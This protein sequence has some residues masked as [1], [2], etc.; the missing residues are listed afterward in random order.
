M[1]P[2]LVL[3]TKSTSRTHRIHGTG[4][5]TYIWLF[6]CGIYDDHGS[7][8]VGPKT[9]YKR[10]LPICNANMY[11]SYFTPCILPGSRG[12][13]PWPTGRTSDVD[14]M[15]PRQPLRLGM[16][17]VHPRCWGAQLP[18]FGGLDVWWVCGCIQ[19]PLPVSRQKSWINWWKFITGLEKLGE[20]VRPSETWKYVAIY[21]GY[22]LQL[23]LKNGPSSKRPTLYDA[24]GTCFLLASVWLQIDL[25]FKGKWHD[26]QVDNG[27][28]L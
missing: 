9:S 18:I 23:H 24:T 4:I 20:I 12:G 17:H 16:K 27:W 15:W 2:S 7:Y 8:R 19:G 11:R 3:Y 22:T 5:L 28:W 26:F 25:P 6:F 1:K 13:T 10:Q 21:R 14:D